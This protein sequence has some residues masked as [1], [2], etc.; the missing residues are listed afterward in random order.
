MKT[1]LKY[2]CKKF[3]HSI[4]NCVVFFMMLLAFVCFLGYCNSEHQNY[5]KTAIE[6]YTREQKNADRSLRGPTTTIIYAQEGEDIEDAKKQSEYFT[7]LRDALYIVKGGY[8]LK[9]YQSISS[10]KEYMNLNMV[11]LDGYES[12]IPM[13]NFTKKSIEELKQENQYY[14]YLIDHEIELEASPYQLIVWNIA[15]QLFNGIGAL[16]VF[17]FFLLWIFDIFGLEFDTGSFKNIYSSSYSRK[18]ILLSKLIF[19]F[20]LLG[21]FLFILIGLLILVGIFCGWGNPMYPC[22][23]SNETLPIWQTVCTMGLILIAG[24]IFM[25][26]FVYAIAMFVSSSS[27]TLI[28]TFITYMT[29]AVLQ[30]ALGLQKI[31]GFIPLCYNETLEIVSNHQNLIALPAG[32][33]LGGLLWYV[34]YVYFKRKDLQNG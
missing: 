10:I 21:I 34:A 31:Y 5:L 7:E 26:F 19:S 2:E 22:M 23:L 20:T 3:I 13:E 16:A 32:C 12:G 6:D 1:L 9:D 33:I 30:Q 17:F 28:I 25:I 8:L 18:E 15:K 4:K 24:L 29:V 14:Q 27:S 11:L